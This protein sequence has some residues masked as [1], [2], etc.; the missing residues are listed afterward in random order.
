M[1][2][3]MSTSAGAGGSAESAASASA[4]AAAESEAAAEAASSE[5]SERRG[6]WEMVFL[7]VMGARE[8]ELLSAEPPPASGVTGAAG[9]SAATASVADAGR[10]SDTAM[11][12]GTAFEHAVAASGTEDE[13][14]S[15]SGIGAGVSADLASSAA[16]SAAADGAAGSCS[17][18]S[19]EATGLDDVESAAS[20]A[21][22]PGASRPEGTMSATA[23]SATEDMAKPSRVCEG[24]LER[25]YHAKLSEI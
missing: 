16:E 5:V 14:A 24:V 17:G 10:D 19:V 15:F 21:S 25:P 12:T 18:M 23:T 6:V 9:V 4:V 2:E 7:G 3:L 13:A 11:N 20:A 8:C 1:M 22:A